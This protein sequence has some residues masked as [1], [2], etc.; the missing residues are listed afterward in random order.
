MNG[1][2]LQP[3][4]GYYIICSWWRPTPTELSWLSSSLVVPEKQMKLWASKFYI[5]SQI[6]WRQVCFYGDLFTGAKALLPYELYK[7]V[8]LV[9]PAAELLT[10]TSSFDWWRVFWVKRQQRNEAYPDIQTLAVAWMSRFNS[11]LFQWKQLVS[12]LFDSGFTEGRV[13]KTE[14]KILDVQNVY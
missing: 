6:L 5:R 10:N 12:G 1:E 9:T 14:R 4:W 7:H 13:F 2:F 3:G 8:F 11:F